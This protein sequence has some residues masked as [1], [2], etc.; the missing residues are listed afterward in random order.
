M[1]PVLVKLPLQQDKQ[2]SSA[3]VW[4]L[5]VAS[6]KKL[7]GFGMCR[8]VKS[9]MKMKIL[10]ILGWQDGLARFQTYLILSK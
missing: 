9:K 4:L 8:K 7:I 5:R 1:P 6:K 2:I 10:S 3:S